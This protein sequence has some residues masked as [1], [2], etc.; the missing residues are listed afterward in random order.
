VFIY[1]FGHK[2]GKE[3]S[4]F[5]GPDLADYSRH[6]QIDRDALPRVRLTGR[7]GLRWKI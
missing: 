2:I 6:T 4:G 5:P 1:G 7:S 3:E